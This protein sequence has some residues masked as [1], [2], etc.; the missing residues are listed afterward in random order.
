MKKYLIVAYVFSMLGTFQNARA[1][2]WKKDSVY[3]VNFH[4]SNFA[5]EK[6]IPVSRVVVHTGLLRE[7][8]P[9]CRGRFFKT[10]PYWEDEAWIPMDHAPDHFFSKKRFHSFV[11]QCQDPVIGPIV[12]Y[13]VYFSDG[14]VR[15]TQPVLVQLNSLLLNHDFSSAGDFWSTVTAF[16]K[17]FGALQDAWETSGK[18]IHWT[19][20]D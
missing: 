18:A 11:G 7:P 13:W 10:G 12:Q 19:R 16:D 20:A 5:F 1:E 15:V 3:W 14:D 6:K 17:E 8:N 4:F 2:T 9:L